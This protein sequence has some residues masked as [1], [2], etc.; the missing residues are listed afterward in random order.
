M[1]L[2]LS[3]YYRVLAKRGGFTGTGIT[4]NVSSDGV[5]FQSERPLTAGHGIRLSIAW[6]ALYRGTQRAELIVY[7]KIVRTE[8]TTAT[9]QTMQ[10]MHYAAMQFKHY[11]FR[12]YPSD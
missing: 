12:P 1:A 9:M 6:P 5:L 3:L 11:K 10:T 2:E 4:R 7:G 8:D